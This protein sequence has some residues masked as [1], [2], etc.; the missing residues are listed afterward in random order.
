MG[1]KGHASAFSL[2][3][4]I[5]LA[6]TVVTASAPAAHQ[7]T[8][9]HKIWP[10]ATYIVR[11]IDQVDHRLFV[12]DTTYG[13]LRQSDD[14]GTTFSKNKGFPQGVATMGKILL[15]K[16]KLFMVGLIRPQDREESTSP[17]RRLG[18]SRW[19]GWTNSYNHSTGSVSSNRF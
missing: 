17:R 9:A 13:A 3:C 5:V 19:F 18:M 7:A 4:G 11:G 2:L 6:T 1:A 10:T 8:A 14:W 16:G 15:F 12:E